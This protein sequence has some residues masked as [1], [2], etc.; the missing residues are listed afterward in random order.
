MAPIQK[1]VRNY[2]E[3]D[4][5]DEIILMRLDT[6][7]LLSLAETAAA[8]WRLIDGQ[9]DQDMLVEALMAQFDGEE[10]EI[11]R[12]VDQ[13]LRELKKAGLIAES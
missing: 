8:A 13:L 10:R 1:L 6:G 5:D 4:I 11:A 12:D 7:E 2:V 3:T 9:R